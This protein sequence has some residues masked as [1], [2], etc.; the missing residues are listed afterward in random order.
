MFDPPL[1]AARSQRPD[2]SAQRSQLI[3]PIPAANQA[4][5]IPTPGQT[6][7]V[8]LGSGRRPRR[9][10]ALVLPRRSLGL[11]DT[12]RYFGGWRKSRALGKPRP[13]PVSGPVPVTAT[14][15]CLVPVLP[16][17]AKTL[18]PEARAT[19]L[20]SVALSAWRLKDLAGPVRTG[21]RQGPCALDVVVVREKWSALVRPRRSVG[22]ARG[23]WYFEARRNSEAKRNTSPAQTSPSEGDTSP[24]TGNQIGNA[25]AGI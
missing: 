16:R 24:L 11:G 22:L 7:P 15:H 23:P 10:P 19:S 4:A 18:F 17:R 21:S 8:V 9:R 25:K 13:A 1:P 20:R 12:P 14:G 6:E 3:D 5:I 2:E